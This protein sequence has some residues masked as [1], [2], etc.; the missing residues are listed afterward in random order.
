MTAVVKMYKTKVVSIFIGLSI[1]V[2]QLNQYFNS[3]SCKHVQKILPI[4]MLK[5]TDFLIILL[6]YYDFFNIIN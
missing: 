2:Y 1:D 3:F 6:R 5:G 4:L